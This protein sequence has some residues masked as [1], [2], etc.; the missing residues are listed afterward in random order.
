M[1]ATVRDIAGGS[2]ALS[3]LDFVHYVI[4]PFR[5]PP[6]DRQAARRDSHGRQRWLDAVWEKARLIVEVDGAGHLEVMQ[7][8]DDMDRDNDLKLQG[9]TTL[10]YPAFAVRYCAAHMASQI[11]QALRNGTLGRPQHVRLQFPS[12]WGQILQALASARMA[13]SGYA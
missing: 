2:H 3:E 1:I 8:W 11:S 12:S 6:P 10:R 4:R 7:Y 13:S 5:L 9:Y